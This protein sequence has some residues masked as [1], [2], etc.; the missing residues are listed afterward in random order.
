M[1]M[2][3]TN[4]LTG[5][6]E[7]LAPKNPPLVRMY[8]CGPTVYDRATIGNFRTY[9]VADLL[10][11][12]LE[13]LNLEPKYIMNIT[14]VGHL[15]GDNL[16]DADT[17][18]DRMEEAAAREAVTAWDIAKRYADQFLA[19]YEALNLL[20]PDKWVKATDHIPDQI[21]LVKTLEEKGYAY[22]TSDGVYFDT[23]KFPAYGALSTLDKIKE[24]ARVGANP[25]KKN[26]RDFALWKFSQPGE[27]R[28]M[29]W[30][31]PW[32]VG[33]PG[34]HLECSAMSM[35]YLGP[36]LDI[37]LGGEDLRSTH[38]PNEIAQSEAVT[39]KTFVRAWVHVAFLQVDGGKMGKSL[40]NAYTLDDIKAHSASPAALKYLYYSAHYRSP[41]NFMW[42][43]LAA[44]ET[45]V[46]RLRGYAAHWKKGE[47]HIAEDAHERFLAAMADDLQTTKALAEVWGMLRA[48]DVSDADKAATL[49]LCDEVLG[50]GLE[51][52]ATG[53]SA[54]EIPAEVRKLVAAR[55]DARKSGDFAAADR[56]RDDIAEKGFDVK[57][58]ATGATITAR[59]GEI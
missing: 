29:E 53:K 38:H 40:G 2:R 20:P 9:A 45:A 23:T 18:K 31:S 24:G 14:D 5:Q 36:E 30:D 51:D 42:E 44:A 48:R 15:T 54:V 58:T 39:G 33:Y 22:R 56:L 41:L 3:L 1:E 46:E 21:A 37:H 8:T 19:D 35:K 49:I 25:E 55:E 11:R 34:W 57:D 13:A 47:G 52:A 7:A 50:L 16:G 26:P 6:V 10:R 43:G 59:K 17:G 32:G 4:S 27:E 12:T 28:Q